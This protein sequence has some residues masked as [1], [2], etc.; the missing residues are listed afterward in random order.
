MESTKELLYLLLYAYLGCLTY[1]GYNLFFYHQKRLIIIKGLLYFLLIF[2]IWIKLDYKY[3]TGFNIF[4]MI[5][6]IIGIIIG[7]I[8]FEIELNKFN[9]KIA[10]INSVLRYYLILATIP[11]IYYYIRCKIHTYKFYKKYPR[12]KPDIYKLF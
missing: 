8:L 6:Y 12:L 4:Y 1:I 10:K 3:Q 7:N 2:F 5:S 9:Q 11:P